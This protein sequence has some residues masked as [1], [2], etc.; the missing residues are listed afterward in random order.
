MLGRFGI[1]QTQTTNNNICYN[2]V[3]KACAKHK[4]VEKNVIPNTCGKHLF[5]TR[6]LATK[7]CFLPLYFL[8]HQQ[9]CI[10]FSIFQLNR[11]SICRCRKVAESKTRRG[12]FHSARSFSH[13][14]MQKSPRLTRDGNNNLSSADYVRRME[15][16]QVIATKW[17][18]FMAL[19]LVFM[20]KLC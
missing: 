17:L 13:F 12:N 20:C 15:N 18:I 6:P 10:S 1:S 2:T 19:S 5:H 11:I 7:N 3:S 8:Q 9:T 14:C 4:L 16:S